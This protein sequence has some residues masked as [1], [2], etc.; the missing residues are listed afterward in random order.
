MEGFISHSYR[1]EDDAPSLSHTLQTP[2][3][4]HVFFT[5]IELTDSLKRP[6]KSRQS[7]DT[8]GEIIS[9]RHKR[10]R[11]QQ[12]Q[13]Q[14][15]K[16]QQQ[17]QLEQQLLEQQLLEQQLLEQQLLEQQ[18]LEQQLLE[19][20]LREQQ[21]LEQQLREQRQQELNAELERRLLGAETLIQLQ[22]EF[23]GLHHQSGS[24]VDRITSDTSNFDDERGWVPSVSVPRSQ[25]EVTPSETFQPGEI[26]VETLDHSQTVPLLDTRQQRAEP[27]LHETFSERDPDN[28][29]STEE[30]RPNGAGT[31]LSET[32][33]QEKVHT[34]GRIDQ[35]QHRTEVL[36]EAG[37]QNEAQ[38]E[39]RIEQYQRQTEV[40]LLEK[41]QRDEAFGGT[42]IECS[43]LQTE[44]ILRDASPQQGNIGN[45]SIEQSQQNHTETNVFETSLEE[46]NDGK[47]NSEQSLLGESDSANW[48]QQH[49]QH[50]TDAVLPEASMQEA[51]DQESWTEQAHQNYAEEFH[52]E[53]HLPDHRATVSPSEPLA[54]NRSASLDL[55]ET[56][57]DRSDDREYPQRNTSETGVI[58]TQHQPYHQPRA[59]VLK[60]REV[61]EC[62]EIAV[63]RRSPSVPT[64]MRE[65]GKEI[66]RE[67]REFQARFKKGIR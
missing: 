17:Q 32:F 28:E 55:S 58:F 2:R 19:Q 45:I 67:R 23:D 29:S 34:E 7:R 41:I 63:V 18:L 4:P 22:Y 5:K 47:G 42:N 60:V 43:Q 37:Q 20:Q 3:R 64:L 59:S 33:M 50:Q 40:P 13:Q 38:I 8:S 31:A 16:Q 11:Q 26:R 14:L 51:V 54:D 48:I 10:R 36:L 49:S 27:S 46:E 61:L 65:D 56:E 53:I 1:Q 21:L 35:C 62:V 52:S 30:Y 15:Q 12:Q 24:S 57:T 66:S 25:A 9:T 39:I 6:P 44:A